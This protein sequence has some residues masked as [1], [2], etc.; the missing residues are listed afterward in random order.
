[1]RYQSLSW[2]M[3]FGERNPPFRPYE[4]SETAVLIF[5]LMEYRSPKQGRVG[6]GRQNLYR[7][8]AFDSK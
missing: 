1:M 4:E 2:R 3:C 8:T 5:L 7:I 6:Y